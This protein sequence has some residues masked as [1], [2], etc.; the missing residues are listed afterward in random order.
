MDIMDKSPNQINIENMKLRMEEIEA[1]FNSSTICLAKWQQTTINLFNGTTNSCHHCPTTKISVTE[2]KNTYSALHNTKQKKLDRMDMMDGIQP[3]SCNYCW[4]IENSEGDHISDRMYKSTDIEWAY[5]YVDKVLQNGPIANIDPSYLEIAF[6]NVCQMSCMYCSPEISSKWMEEVETKGPYK[7]GIGDLTW[8]KQQDRM[9]IPHKDYN[10]YVEAFWKWWPTLQNSIKVLRI[11]GG[12]PLL[13]KDFWKL[14]DSIIE[15]PLPD[16]KLVVNTN[17]M[18]PKPLLDK[19]IIY[20]NLVQGK[21]KEFEIYTSCEAAFEQAEYIRYGLNYNQFFKNIADYIEKT[22]HNYRVNFMITFNALSL[23][24]F[25]EFLTDILELRRAY[26]E[27]DGFNR[28]PFVISY[29]RWP[30]FQDVRILS[31]EFK[32]RYINEIEEFMQN[33]D[34][35]NSEYSSGRFYLEEL[36]QIARLKEYALTKLEE[37]DLQKRLIDFKSF[38]NEYDERRGTDFLK[39]FPEYKEFYA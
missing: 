1:K 22:P 15:N 4:N 38:Y 9:P 3:K 21:I 8:I 10:P 37:V 26:N 18:V 14:L 33:N 24:S 5:P 2:I 25:K 23:T 27:D 7:N 32:L 30:Q 17:M 16:L 28:I 34:R 31:D 12:E 35:N 39:V 29:L 19:L 6:S 36:D 11:T 13:S 20:A